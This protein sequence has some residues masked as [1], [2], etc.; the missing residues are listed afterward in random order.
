MEDVAILAHSL[1]LQVVQKLSQMILDQKFSGI[2]EQGK[3]HLI[4]YD[5]SKEDKSFTRA[6]EIIGN[7]G[8]AVD[9]LYARAKKIG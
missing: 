9:V 2:L 4:V 5:S 6:L 3:G 8:Q 7:L 1:I